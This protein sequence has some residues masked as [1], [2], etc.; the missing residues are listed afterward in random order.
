MGKVDAA[1]NFDRYRRLLAEATDESKRLAFIQL[2]IEE[3][4]R[5]RLAEHTQRAGRSGAGLRA[6]SSPRHTMLT[7]KSAR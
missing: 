2:L 7:E 1:Y 4:A 5:D 3:K 6:E